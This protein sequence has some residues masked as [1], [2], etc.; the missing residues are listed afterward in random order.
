MGGS[1][2][3]RPGDLSPEEASALVVR[4]A[5]RAYR[6]P[7]RV[8]GLDRRGGFEETV[9][10]YTAEEA[11]REASR[12]LDCDRMCSLC[13][14][15]C[16]NVA[17]MTYATA[18]VHANLPTLVVRGGAV[19]ST[20]SSPFVVDQGLQVA[21]LT[22]LCNECGNCVTACPTGGR[23]YVDKPRLYLDRD[24]FEAQVSNAFM[25]LGG[26]VIEGRFD[27]RT[28]RVR[29]HGAGLV[30]SGAAPEEPGG[31]AGRAA[32]RIEYIAPGFRAALD[33]ETL[34]LVEAESTGAAEGETLSLEPAAVMVTV[35][36]GITGSLPHLPVTGTGGTRIP[37]PGPDA[38]V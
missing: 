24:D 21:V 10:G 15:V 37:A 38:Q 27:G 23:P 30:T 28:H 16:P 2:A 36:D 11:E 35:L 33:G 4:R 1:A 18:P 13:V 32:R 6:V 8:T 9:L 17:L 14:G 26:R 29:M 22:D 34:A 3:P 12:C 7:V 20:G 19:V 5:R 25:L 31:G